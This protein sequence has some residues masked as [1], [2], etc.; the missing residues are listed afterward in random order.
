M[1]S[2]IGQLSVEGYKR[3]RVE[4]VAPATVN[5]EIALL[6]HMYN[7]AEAWGLFHGRNPVRGVRLLP[8]NNLKLR[9]LSEEEETKLLP[10]CPQYLRDMVLFALHTGLRSG[11]IFRLQWE[12]INTR[13]NQLKIIVRKTQQE[14]E[15]P[16][17]DEGVAIL[18]KWRT[19]RCCPYVFF[20]QLTGDRFHDLK[21]SLNKAIKD[22]GLS[23]ITWHTFRHTFA[24]RLIAQGTDIVTVKELLGHAEI[25]TTMRYAHT[26]R[27]AKRGAVKA[28]CAKLVTV[29]PEGV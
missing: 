28:L 10:L 7:L 6:K 1:L 5:R 19:V 25:K 26:S 2:D 18:E 12:D 22:A 8:E 20:N 4:H 13:E 9:I 14:L 16:L 11:D 24:T 29:K 23:G 15:L 3:Q 27:E 21:A 17:S